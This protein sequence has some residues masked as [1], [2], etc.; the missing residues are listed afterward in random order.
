MSYEFKVE[1]VEYIRHEGKPYLATLYRPQGTG[2]FPIIVELHGG[3][4][5]ASSV[6]G[7]GSRFTFS[8]PVRK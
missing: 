6:V 7:Q 5:W 4:I 2:P 8:L 1:D 3:A